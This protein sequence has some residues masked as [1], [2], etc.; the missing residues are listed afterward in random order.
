M[1]DKYMM[2]D[3]K[4]EIV[5]TQY[6]EGESDEPDVIEIKTT[7]TLFEKDHVQYLKY[8]EYI[9]EGTHVIDNLVRFDDRHCR[10]TKKGSV[11]TVMAF[12]INENGTAHYQT[13]AGPLYLRIMTEEYDVTRDEHSIR[14]G[15]SYTIDFNYSYV[16][17]NR[18]ELTIWLD[19]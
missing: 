11:N 15:M 19:S 5:G 2:K 16:T 9:D 14:L 17:C 8:Q 3:V 13:P 12:G 1:K 7:G 6:V 10:I 4:I 18:L